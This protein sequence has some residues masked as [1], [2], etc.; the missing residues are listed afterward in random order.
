MHGF[1]II[2]VL[3]LLSSGFLVF[4]LVNFL[5]ASREKAFPPQ[6]D[7]AAKTTLF[8]RPQKA[9]LAIVSRRTAAGAVQPEKDS[10]AAI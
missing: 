7:P 10:G 9:R 6:N 4:C 2:F 8:G 3:C 1:Q 5:K